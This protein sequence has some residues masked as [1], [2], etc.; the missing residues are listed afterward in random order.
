MRTL[1]VKSKKGFTLIEILITLAITVIVGG[2][3]ASYLVPQVN[4]F[5]INS[6]QSNAR[7]AC[8]GIINELQGRL[9]CGKDFVLNGDTLTY[10][11]VNE[12]SDHAGEKI[13]LEKL[14][15]Q[16]FPNLTKDK[17]SIDIKLNLKYAG[18]PANGIEAFSD[19]P[20]VLVTITIFDEEGKE[21]YTQ[22]Q[23]VGCPNWNLEKA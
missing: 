2:F 10:T 16:L 6:R 7:S 15:Q 9:Y 3:L 20:A 4:V 12:N 14:G 8:A 13:E 11:H 5:H 18:D 21:F 1:R 22:S 19:K 23:A 17:L